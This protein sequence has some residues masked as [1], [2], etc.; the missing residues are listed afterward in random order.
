MEEIL[1]IREEY[2][3]KYGE[4]DPP[5]QFYDRLLSVGSIPPALVREELFA[6]AAE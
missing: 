1:A 3:E 4:P 5:S 2:I 6:P